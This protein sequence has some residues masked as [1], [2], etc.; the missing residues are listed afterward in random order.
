[1][2]T[3]KTLVESDEKPEK[4]LKKTLAAASPCLPRIT[5]Y[6]IAVAKVFF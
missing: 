1:M 2:H 4:I 3:G 5:M 6:V